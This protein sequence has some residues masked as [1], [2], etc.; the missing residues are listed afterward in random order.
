[1]GLDVTGSHGQNGVCQNKEAT[2]GPWVQG[3]GER[4][5]LSCPAFGD[6]PEHDLQ[7][8]ALLCNPNLS[9]STLT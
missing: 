9:K 8:A 1:M 7:G 4:P 6:F 3:R 5:S 2:E